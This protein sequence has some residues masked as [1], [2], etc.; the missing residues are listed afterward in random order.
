MLII[1][2]N[3]IGEI[4]CANIVKS[5]NPY[6]MIGI[7]K[8]FEKWLLNKITLLVFVVMIMTERI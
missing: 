3:K 1:T 4:I 2:V 8:E 6:F 5:R 7:Q